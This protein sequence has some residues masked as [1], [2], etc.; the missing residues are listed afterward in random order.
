[1]ATIR[2]DLQ[3]AEFKRPPFLTDIILPPLMKEQIA[4]TLYY[5]KVLADN[6]AQSGRAHAETIGTITEHIVA[7]STKTFSCEE[8]RDRQKMSYTQVKGYADLLHAELAMARRAK[9]AWFN[10]IET[11]TAKALLGA[12]SPLDL[13]GS[14]ADIPGDIENAVAELQDKAPGKIALVLSSRNFTKLKAN[15]S[16]KD[17]MKNTGVV[18]GAGGDP[19][20]VT[21]EQLAAILGVDQLLIG[22]N[23]VWFAA[24]KKN[25]TASGGSD[26]FDYQGNAALVVLPDE[27][28]EPAEEIQL[29]RTIYYKWS[30]DGDFYVCESYHEDKVDADCV[31]VKGLVDSQILNADLCKTVKLF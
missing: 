20:M 19:R 30:S 13:T 10:K 23:D 9:R 27:A 3:A 22:P 16:I 12:A 29:G 6:D 18:V 1:M 24:M 28:T 5:Q 26:G 31:D 25:P 11:A 21:A 7:A 17:R 8:V 2:P 15:D 4:G 14:T